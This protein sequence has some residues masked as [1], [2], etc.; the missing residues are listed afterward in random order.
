MKAIGLWTIF[1][2]SCLDYGLRDEKDLTG[3]SEAV[4]DS[5]PPPVRFGNCGD[6]AAAHAAEVN[7]PTCTAVGAVDW[8]MELEWE[9][10]VED[11]YVEAIGALSPIGHPEG[12]VVVNWSE[13]MLLSL[14]GSTGEPIPL[15]SISS[16][17]TLETSSVANSLTG[18]TWLC[19]QLDEEP[20]LAACQTI[21]PGGELLS[22]YTAFND[23][24]WLSLQDVD[25]DGEI[26]IVTKMGTFDLDGHLIAS[27]S[28][29]DDDRSSAYAADLDEDGD[30]E[31]VT[32]TGIWDALEGTQTAWSDGLAD[33]YHGGPVMDGEELALI[34]STEHG[35][36]R[37]D[38]WGQVQWTLKGGPSMVAL[39]DVDGDGEP[40]ICEYTGSET[41]IVSLDGEIERSW[42]R[43]DYQDNYVGGCSLAD[44]DGDG[45][46]EIID[47][48]YGGLFIRS[49]ITGD[50]L[51]SES[52]HK[53]NL[54]CS[55]PLIADVD[56]DGS[57]EIVAWGTVSAGGDQ[58][59]QAV[60]VYG[61][62]R[63]RWARTRRVWNQATYH[64][65][66]VTDDGTIRRWPLPP[67]RV[68]NSFRAQPANDGHKPDLTVEISDSCAV[69]CDQGEPNSPVYLALQVSNL[70][71]A[72]A[73]EGAVVRLYQDQGGSDL[74]E[75][76]SYVVDEA[77][78]A[79]TALQGFTVEI[80]ADDWSPRMLLTIEGDADECDP[81]NDRIE[82]EIQPCSFALGR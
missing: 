28:G 62:R 52:R 13:G 65:S 3:D 11:G 78:P 20:G 54:I 64:P 55:P 10:R 49:G 26:E 38:I 16:N 35:I 24:Q 51:A 46:F 43:S 60:R 32:S 39:G 73:V 6:L 63:G 47:F 59:Y 61:P 33:L 4:V 21:L 53:T 29:V 27:F 14:D 44:L 48:S 70:G 74:R 30:M 82:V 50:T 5:A 18:E 17:W 81:N 42:I 31:V 37:A 40:E 80:A 45:V 66:M 12:V 8:G 71:S 79:A 58:E 68:S 77:V 25:F 9:Y 23:N 1:L 7:P 69:Q 34:G 2:A 36:Q 75:V 22:G 67:W 41:R 19:G 56:H 57:A 72:E 76:V 15:A